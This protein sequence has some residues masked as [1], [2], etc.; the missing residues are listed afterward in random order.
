MRVGTNFR[1]SSAAGVCRLVCN[2]R[3]RQSLRSMVARLK[4]FSGRLRA[5]GRDQG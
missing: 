5:E 3:K 2:P 4:V 1:V